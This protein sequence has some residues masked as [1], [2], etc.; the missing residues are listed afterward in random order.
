MVR[1]ARIKSANIENL[2]FL[3]GSAE[4][5]PCGDQ[6]F[7]KVLS[8]SAFYYFEH[9]EKVLTEL[10]HVVATEGQLSLLNCFTR[11]YL[12]GLLRYVD[13][14]FRYTF[15]ARMSTNVCYKPQDGE[16]YARRSC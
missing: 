3:C 1:R 11:S 2:A 8:A 5:I 9:Q 15:A 4:H 10:F 6:V 12:T 7:T 16:M 13:G 14:E